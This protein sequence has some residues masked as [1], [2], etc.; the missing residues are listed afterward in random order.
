MK[1]TILNL[2]VLSVLISIFSACSGSDVDEKFVKKWT[3]FKIDGADPK[4]DKILGI[5]YIFF[6]LREDGTY[7]GKWYK[8]DSMT[9]FIDL[10]GTWLT[11]AYGENKDNYDLF[12]FYGPGNKKSKIF[13]VKSIENDIMVMKISDIDHYFKAN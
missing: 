9:D 10:K 6:D 7:D 2:L 5:N 11:T 8:P 3:L 12:L 4:N 13:T 1:K